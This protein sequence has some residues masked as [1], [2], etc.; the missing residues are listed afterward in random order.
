MAF[1]DTEDEYGRQVEVAVGNEE[2]DGTGTW[3]CLKTDSDGKVEIT[4]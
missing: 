1:T 3:H 4:S 2:E